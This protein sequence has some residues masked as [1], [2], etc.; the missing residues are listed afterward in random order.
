MDE[1]DE[2]EGPQTDEDEP[3][4]P[5]DRFRKIRRV[6][7]NLRQIAKLGFGPNANL[8]AQLR[9]LEGTEKERFETIQQEVPWWQRPVKVAK[10]FSKTQGDVEYFHT[11]RELCQKQM[12][13]DSKAFQEALGKL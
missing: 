12:E 1:V 6:K 11:Q 7:K 4:K 13:G 5:Q 3:N 9:Q 10:A 2:E 8:D